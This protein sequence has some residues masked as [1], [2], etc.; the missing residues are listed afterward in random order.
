MSSRW[1][2]DE[3]IFF[4]RPCQTLQGSMKNF[5]PPVTVEIPKCAGLRSPGGACTWVHSDNCL[6]IVFTL[7]EVQ[8]NR[9]KMICSSAPWDPALVPSHPHQ[10]CLNLVYMLLVFAL[11]FF[12][13]KKKFLSISGL[14]WGFP[15]RTP[16]LFL[17][18]HGAPHRFYGRPQS[19]STVLG[20]PN[21]S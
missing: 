15:C 19:W 18:K 1:T 21:H 2:R 9:F 10:T 3:R 13:F 6:L 11:F 17:P 20:S 16:G 14:V 12:S 4:I 5:T 8:L 7:N